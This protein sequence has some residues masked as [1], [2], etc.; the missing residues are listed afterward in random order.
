MSPGDFGRDNPGGFEHSELMACRNDYET[1][2]VTIQG[3]KAGSMSAQ[4]NKFLGYLSAKRAEKD[5]SVRDG[6]SLRT[7]I[8]FFCRISYNNN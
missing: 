2:I 8:L 3:G 4:A 6:R 7:A 1:E 5:S